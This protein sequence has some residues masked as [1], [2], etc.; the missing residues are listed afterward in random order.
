MAG[1]GPQSYQKQ[2]KEQ[3][4]KEKQQEKMA[5]R[6]ER[7]RQAEPPSEP[8]HHKRRSRN[9]ENLYGISGIGE[10]N[11]APAKPQKPLRP[12][13][14]VTEA[15]TS[16]R[17]IPENSAAV[18]RFKAEPRS[19]RFQRAQSPGMIEVLNENSYVMA[20]Y[21]ER[22]GSVK[23]RRV[24]AASERDQIENWLRNHY[25]SA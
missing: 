4:R 25:P 7:K 13:P 16:R 15:S 6:L 9:R 23:W 1:R 12:L 20:E 5:K 22:T 17:Q 21:S 3:Q 11:R 19:Y 24:V 18:Q 8:L 10:A 2:L 14:G